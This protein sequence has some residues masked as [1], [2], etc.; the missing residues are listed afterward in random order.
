MK[1]LRIDRTETVLTVTI[2]RPDTCNALSDVVL[3]ELVDVFGKLGH[4]E[5]RGVILTGAGDRAFVAGADIAVMAGLSVSAG[6]AFCRLGQEVTELIESAPVPVIAAV[7]G[8]ALGGGCDL[9]L[10]C[11]YILA[12]ETAT[13]GQPAVSLGLIPGFGGCVRLLQRVGPGR[14]KELIY[15]G[16]AITAGEALRIGLVNAVYATR[17]DLLAAAHASIAQIATRSATAVS[18]CK[19]V[20]HSLAGKSMAAQLSL[21]ASGFERAFASADKREGVAAFL[22]KRPPVFPGR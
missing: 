13:F 21:E 19:H 6:A 16:R 4:G 9:A 18:T 7:N 11:D 14:A 10:A 17:K 12:T 22:A 3:R 1:T 20:L 5:V 2:D 8:Y 15:T